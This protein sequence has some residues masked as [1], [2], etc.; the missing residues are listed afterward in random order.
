MVEKQYRLLEINEEGAYEMQKLSLVEGIALR[1]KGLLDN[2]GPSN[3]AFTDG[4]V[5]KFASSFDLYF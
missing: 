2:S 5:D 4:E 1:V 3:M